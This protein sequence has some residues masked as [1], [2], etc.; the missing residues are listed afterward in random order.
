MAQRTFTAL[1]TGF[2]P[3]EEEYP[4]NP[5][6]EISQSLPPSLADHHVKINI[7]P[8]P[9]PL[10]VSYRHVS[11]LMPAILDSYAGS[12]DMVL[13]I[14][15]YSGH[16]YAVERFGHANGYVRPDLYGA[17]PTEQDERLGEKLETSFRV[18]NVIRKWQEETCTAGYNAA[19]CCVSEDAGRFLCDFTYFTT[20]AWY[21]KKN[22]RFTATFDRPVLFLHVPADNSV[23]KG[24]VFAECLLKASA[25]CY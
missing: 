9:S 7:V 6:Y 20:L 16:A 24:R 21:G 11:E 22:K 5:S 13:H 17:L 14:G 23:E 15:M 12:V 18:Q 10:R 19:E 4:V 25:A 1:V 3:F 2:E 8:L